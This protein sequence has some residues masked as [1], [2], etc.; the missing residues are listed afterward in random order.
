MKIIKRYKNRKLYDTDESVYVTLAELREA[1]K[2]DVEFQVVCDKTKNDI[3]GETLLKIVELN[4]RA[5]SQQPDVV[6]LRRVISTGQGT[7]TGLLSF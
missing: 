3:T 1:I 4:E 6:M 5:V 7:F 2:Q